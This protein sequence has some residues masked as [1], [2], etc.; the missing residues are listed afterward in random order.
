MKK[1][2]YLLLFVLL[3]LGLVA[4]PKY[5]FYF[6]GDGM[7]INHV[8]L[9]QM[10]LS[11]LQGQ[12]G[13]TPLTMTSFPYFGILATHSAS[14]PITDSA[15]AGTC[16][17]S[18]KKTSNGT[19]GMD[20]E[21][22]PAISIAE[23]LKTLGWAV[24]I[25]TTVSIDH[26]T[27]GA[28]YAHVPNRSELFTIGT[29]LANTNYDLFMGSGFL[30]PDGKLDGQ[31]VNLYDYCTEKG[32]TIAY[33]NAD[34]QNH[35]DTDKLIVVNYDEGKDKPVRSKLP[36]AMERTPQDLTLPQIL[37]TSIDFLSKKDKPFFVMA[38]GGS[39][40]WASHGNDAYTVIQEVLEF[41]TAINVAY[42]FYQS[43]PDETLIIVTADHETG[44]LALGR[45]GYTLDLK[46]LNNQKVC[47]D[48]VN[49][50]IKAVHAQLGAKIQW[51]DVKNILTQY[52]GLY[53]TVSVTKEEDAQLQA[54]FNDIKKNTG[55]DVKTLYSSV[56]E[57][58]ADAVH[59]LDAKALINWGTG[60]HSASPVPVFAIGAGAEKFTG[61]HDNSYIAKTLEEILC[62]STPQGQYIAK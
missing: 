7:G 10:Y 4:Q 35:L 55:K 8:R 57:I 56:Y 6:I 34:A 3:P 59:L 51:K 42:Q 58:S 5:V 33:G 53:T 40:D 14:N 30:K 24:G 47:T 18:G 52:L 46:A 38:E 2:L 45:K 1:K 31:D 22:R 60:A 54:K 36:Y 29:Q 16:L 43:H 12:I 9:T 37:T 32:Y 48:S 50:T 20:A 28:F 21:E 41:D 25:T 13:C 27:P 17:A 26:A 44:G 19:L 15:A 23:Q 11:A 62:T 49:A 39:I 61:C